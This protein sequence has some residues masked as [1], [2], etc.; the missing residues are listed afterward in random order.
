MI[1]LGFEEYNCEKNVIQRNG[2]QVDDV[3]FNLKRNRG[4]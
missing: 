1:Q 4:K 3:Y 2:N